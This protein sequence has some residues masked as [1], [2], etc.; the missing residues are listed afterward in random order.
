M[1]RPRGNVEGIGEVEES[2]FSVQVPLPVHEKINEFNRKRSVAKP[3][4]I[5]NVHGV[6]LRPHPSRCQPGV[7][8]PLHWV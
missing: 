3:S 1:N 8:S 6:H 4:E 7:S 5:V 2:D